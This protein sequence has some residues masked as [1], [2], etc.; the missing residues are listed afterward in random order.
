M[1]GQYHGRFEVGST[2][3]AY[4]K[5]DVYTNWDTSQL[6]DE[7]L[8]VS[9]KPPFWG[10]V[11]RG[12]FL[13]PPGRLEKAHDDVATILLQILDEGSISQGRKVDFKV[14]P[15]NSSIIQLPLC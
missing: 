13:F 8:M 3:R 14:F 12:F 11:E 4:I 2:F 1:G 10:S 15:T 7:N 6:Y 9:C 5:K